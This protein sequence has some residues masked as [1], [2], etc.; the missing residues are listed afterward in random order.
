MQIILQTKLLSVDYHL[1]KDPGYNLQLYQHNLQSGTSQLFGF[2]TRVLFIKKLI[3]GNILNKKAI[4]K[5]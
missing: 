4:K 2:P 3:L 5:I 1:D